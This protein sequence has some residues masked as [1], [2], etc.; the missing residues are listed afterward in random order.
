MLRSRDGCQGNM[1]PSRVL[2]QE[3]NTITFTL[4]QITMAVG[5]TVDWNGEKEDAQR[6]EGLE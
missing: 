2:R 3:C 5:E 4:L 6:S 1:E